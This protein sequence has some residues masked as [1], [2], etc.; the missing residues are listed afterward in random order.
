MKDFKVLKSYRGT[1]CRRCNANKAYPL[2]SYHSN[3]L[4]IKILKVF[5]VV[6][7]IL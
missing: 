7:L 1:S 6:A 3:L 2:N 5:P 4:I